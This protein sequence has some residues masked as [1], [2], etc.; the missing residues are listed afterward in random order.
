MALARFHTLLRTRLA[1]GV[2]V[3]ALHLVA[4]ALLI[5]A[6]AP[7]VVGKVLGPVTA[8]FDVRVTPPPPPKPAAQPKSAPQPGRAAPPGKKASPREVTAPKPKIVVAQAPAPPVAGQGSA[9]QSG[10]RDTGA[11]TGAAG[12]GQGTGAGGSGTGAGGGGAS[13][14]VKIAGDIV[15]ARDYPAA[16]RALRLGSAVT[17]ALTVGTDG[18]V[19]GCRIVRA[20]RDPEADRVTCQLATERFR[21]R[22][23]RDANG[24]PVASMYGWQ[25]RWFTPPGK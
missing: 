5:R 19:A 20:S 4:I 22:P 23:A 15:S 9:D 3:A 6:F 13:K 2:F 8:A 21:F 7:G 14:A 18:R 10:A 25:Q 24:L 12:A 16:A 11:G 17:I 1:I